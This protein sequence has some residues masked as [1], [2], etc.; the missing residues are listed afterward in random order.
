MREIQDIIAERLG[1]DAAALLADALE[2][3]R[4]DALR[5][6]VR[7]RERLAR[8]EARA[9]RAEMRAADEEMRAAAA[10]RARLDEERALARLV[11]ARPAAWLPAALVAGAVV[12]ACGA[13]YLLAAG[14]AYVACR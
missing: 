8:A 4:D 3:A 9:L 6:L 12:G 1:R 7:A 10:T 5:R 2:S 11:A 14:V 13:A